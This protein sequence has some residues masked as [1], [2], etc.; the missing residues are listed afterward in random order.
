MTTQSS[1]P[2]RWRFDTLALHGGDDPAYHP[3]GA[4]LPPI[5]PTTTYTFPDVETARATFAGERPGYVYA[6]RG[7]PNADLMARKI[8]LLEAFDFLQDG[9]PEDNAAHGLV[10]A[11]GMAAITAAI[12][13]RAQK[14][15]VILAPRVIYGTTYAFFT[16]VLPQWGLRVVWVDQGDLDAWERAF[17]EHVRVTWAYIET[18]ANPT[19]DITDIA[20][21]VE[22]AHRYGAW[23]I[24]D[25]TFATPYCQR[26]LALGVDVVVHSTTKYLSGHGQAL[27]GAV[28][29]RDRDYITG[30][31]LRMLL[32]LGGVMAPF[33]AWMTTMGMK[34][35]ALRMARHCENARTVAEYLAQHPKI[36]RV[37]YPGL[38][39]FPGH[40]IAKRQ[41]HCF[42]GMV[43]FELKGGYDA[44]VRL[45]NSLRLPALGVSLG[46]TDSIIEHPASMTHAK[47]PPEERRAMGI[48]DGL[49]RFSVG[50]EAAEDIL[51]DLDQALA[52]I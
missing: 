20:G 6:R 48:S 26:P 11:S 14:A 39:D 31:L 50:L 9:M 45:M 42:G 37:Y 4:H 38:P 49:V 5:F 10:F 32:V 33:E 36:A 46:K 18:P 7:H 47:I 22:I 23:V 21:V 2:S 35:F 44:G 19:L 1:S 29:S 17:R 43:S 40:E 28:I 16:H 52:R 12:L 24:A 41:M 8:A 15:D 13:A 3:L 34:T 30:P 25:N 51:A 27:G